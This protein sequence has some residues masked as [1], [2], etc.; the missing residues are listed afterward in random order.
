[1]LSGQLVIAKITYY[2]L[3]STG[4]RRVHLISNEIKQGTQL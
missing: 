2:V 1:M 4:I 3:N